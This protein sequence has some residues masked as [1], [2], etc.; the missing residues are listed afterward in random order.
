M[1][2]HTIAF[3][4]KHQAGSPEEREFLADTYRF[5][6]IP[7]VL[8]FNCFRQTSRQN[9]FEFGISME[10]ATQEDYDRYSRHPLHIKLVQERWLA[11]VSDFLELDYTALS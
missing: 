11:E 5:A 9:A 8:N 4:L 3:K 7:G 6:E 1:I 10:F 2:Q